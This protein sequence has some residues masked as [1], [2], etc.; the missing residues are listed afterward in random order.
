MFLKS[1]IV[2]TRLTFKDV[3]KKAWWIA[4]FSE[5]V[6]IFLFYVFGDILSWFSIDRDNLQ[7]LTQ[8]YSIANQSE[9]GSSQEDEDIVILDINEM[10]DG[11]DFRETF[12]H[13]LDT[14]CAY[15]PRVVGIDIWFSQPRDANADDSLRAAVRR[16]A[17][18]LVLATATS[19][20]LTLF[21]SIL[22][23]EAGLDF[24]TINLAAYTSYSPSM[25]VGGVDVPLFSWAVARKAGADLPTD[26]DRFLVDYSTVDFQPLAAELFLQGT[27]AER[28]ENVAGK[29]VLLGDTIDPKDYHETPFPVVGQKMTEGVLLHAY[30]IRSLLDRDHAFR[31]T[32]TLADLLI[33]LAMTF[34]F[35]IAFVCFVNWTEQFR[36]RR[37]LYA[38]LL[39]SRPLLLILANILVWFLALHGLTLPLRLVPNVVL[40]MLSVL[41]INTFNDAITHLFSL[42]ETK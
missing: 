41:L 13:L 14:V 33:C 34:L 8:Y 12:A 4:L 36:D 6:A 11:D 40:Y 35:A 2:R 19:D 28:L 20:G 26:L 17:D 31:K 38:C 32:G 21:P 22:D 9:T 24:G 23:G 30:A 18:K 16:N 39:V 7:Y 5:L 1:L 42:N 3:L 29:V 37:T 27:D 15:G 10:G 25:D